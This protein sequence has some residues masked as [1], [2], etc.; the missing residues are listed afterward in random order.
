M[1]N[2]YDTI[3]RLAARRAQMVEPVRDNHHLLSDLVNFGSNPGALRAR[4]YVPKNL[5]G[6]VPLVVVLHGCTQTAAKA[7]PSGR[8]QPCM[9]PSVTR[10]PSFRPSNRSGPW[11]GCS[12]KLP[13][14]DTGAW[15]QRPQLPWA[16]P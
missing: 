10:I 12:V 4:T 14:R 9:V 5:P 3:S 15:A 13:V 2:L 16:W 8:K 11:T 7:R 6:T 1:R